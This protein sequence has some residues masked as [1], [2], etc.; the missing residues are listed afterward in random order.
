MSVEDEI[1]K[2]VLK[3]EG[4]IND[5]DNSGVIPSDIPLTIED[6]VPKDGYY[7][8]DKNLRYDKFKHYPESMQFDIRAVTVNEIKHWSTLNDK[9]QDPREIVKYFNHMLEKCVR[10]RGGSW[11]DIKPIDRFWFIA[12]LHEITFAETERP[13]LIKCTCKKEECEGHEFNAN[14]TKDVLTYKFP[15]DK[16]YKYLNPSTGGFEV[17]T[18]SY[19]T[20]HINYPSIKVDNAVMAYI[21]E[22]KPQWVKQ[23]A[24]F[25]EMATFLIPVGTAPTSKVFDNLFVKYKSWNDKQFAFM[26]NLIEDI[27]IT[28][29]DHFAVRCPKCGST[30]DQA[31]DLEGGIRGLFLAV[32]DIDN[33]LL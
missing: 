14:L 30:T 33:E 12:Y 26:Y 13:S 31:F 19:G 9:V 17:K 15:D 10:V 21:S 5:E 4:N 25:L 23:N 16:Y 3:A 24:T 8:V 7:R 32:S 6:T 22:A 29:N 20:I 1:A 18:S 27:K 11:N 2:A 28:P